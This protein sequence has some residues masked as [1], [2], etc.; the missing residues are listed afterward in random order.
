M[1]IKELVLSHLKETLLFILFFAPLLSIGQ[2][3]GTKMLGDSSHSSYED[4]S[5]IGGPKTV[6]A[7]LAVDNRKK[8]FYFRMPIKVTKPWFD[9]KDSVYKKTGI[10]FGI[11]YTSVYVHSSAVKNDSVNKAGAGSG[12]LDINLGWNF[13]NRKKGKNKGTLFFR[14]NDRHTYGGSSNTSPMFHGINESGYYGLPAVGFRDYSMRFLELNYQQTF[15][16]DVAHLVVGKVD[17]TN[18][19]NFHGLIVPW[20]HF[21]GY[22]ASVSGTVNWPNQGVGA[23]F[24][25]RPQKNIYIMGGVSDAYGDRYEDDDWLDMGRTFDDDAFFKA[26]EVGYVPSF[27][28]R[29]FKKISLMYWETDGYNAQTESDT[30]AVAESKGWAFSAHWFF[31]ERYVPFVRLAT[32]DGNGENAFYKSDIQLGCGFRFKSHDMIGISF[33]AA[34]PNIPDVDD[35][36]TME[37]FYRFNLTPGLEITPDFQYIMNPTLNPNVSDLVYFGIRGRINM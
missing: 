14:I 11:S 33:S 25:I 36:Y 37:L 20:Q 13:I 9:L 19:F 15:F 2:E 1:T 8:D 27:G 17:P 16:N 12:R 31:K 6:G 24:D 18:Y 34:D 23:V 21:L 4:E 5:V 35:Q 22:G 7:Q 29:Y 3:N 10:Q 28:E 26:V 30:F 32:S